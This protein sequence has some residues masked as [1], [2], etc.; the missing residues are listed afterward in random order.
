MVKPIRICGVSHRRRGTTSQRGK[1]PITPVKRPELSIV[2]EIL[3]LAVTIPGQIDALDTGREAVQH[4]QIETVT[5]TRFTAGIQ[6]TVVFILY[7]IIRVQ[8]HYSARQRC[9]EKL[10]GR[11]PTF[12]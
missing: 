1:L 2:W 4:L 7:L 10:D 8:Q 5:N 9:F 12:G 3:I 6:I 11:K